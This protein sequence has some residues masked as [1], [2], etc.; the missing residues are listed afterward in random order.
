MSARLTCALMTSQNQKP[1]SDLGH[2][3]YLTSLLASDEAPGSAASKF[4]K[5]HEEKV[6][7]GGGV[8]WLR[9]SSRFADA[10][11]FRGLEGI[12]L[13]LGGPHAHP[14]IGSESRE[15]GFQMLLVACVARAEIPLEVNNSAAA[16]PPSPS[17]SSKKSSSDPHLAAPDSIVAPVGGL[18]VVSSNTAILG[19]KGKKK[20]LEA[21][22]ANADSTPEPDVPKTSVSVTLWRRAEAGQ[23]AFRPPNHNLGFF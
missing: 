21:S 11:T 4:G 14:A 3:H 18:L 8:G 22:K 20:G 2:H 9:S 23:D 6:G 1:Y 16:P 15:V 19:G 10:P 7:G 13:L 5:R 17:P 12:S